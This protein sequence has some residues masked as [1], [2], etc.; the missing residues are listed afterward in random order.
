[1][2]NP[3]VPSSSVRD[4]HALRVLSCVR[5]H[6][7]VSRAAVSRLEHLSKSTVTRL[8]DQLLADGLLIETGQ[9]DVPDAKRKPIA[10]R[11]NPDAHYCIG[12]NASRHSLHYVVTDF[13]GELHLNERVSIG[14]L[15]TA[16]EFVRAVIEVIR[17]ALLRTGAA[18]EK[19]LGVGVGIPGLVDDQSGLILNF[20]SESRWMNVP[21]KALLEKEFPFP[22]HVDND[23]NTLILSEQLF[24]PGE[25]MSNCVFANCWDGV[26]S[27]VI[28][29]GHLL[30]GYSNSVGEIGHMVIEPRG[31]LC[32]CGKS[33]CVEAYCSPDVL[34]ADVTEALRRGRASMLGSP[35]DPERVTYQDV[36]ACFEKGDPLCV[37]HVQRLAQ[38][39][40]ICLSNT[41]N[42]LN[43]KTMIIS[44]ELFEISE[45][46]FRIVRDFTCEMLIS[47]MNQSVVFVKRSV[48]D[49][50]YERG[51][52]SL[53]YNA[54]YSAP[55]EA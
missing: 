13:A 34:C 49:K 21:L 1:M 42:I 36:M 19:V 44:G 35:A 32:T 46:F 41:I 27:A 48:K 53:V 33:G 14:G 31:R 15:K 10:L 29:G 9:L 52:V 20:A 7:P 39:L 37:E 22:A 3:S 24:N 23:V 50:I 18:P 40:S 25:D 11:L 55:S 16:D 30:R 12:V 26:G 38:Y 8:V 43:P 28:M 51:A 2:T 45:A 6:A 17:D 47:Q 4:L 54:F 5:D